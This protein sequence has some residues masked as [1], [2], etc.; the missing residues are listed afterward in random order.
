MM[1]ENREISYLHGEAPRA[2]FFTSAYAFCQI[3]NSTLL[4][5]D[6]SSSLPRGHETTRGYFHAAVR[7]KNAGKSASSR[8]FILRPDQW[9]TFK[10][11]TLTFTLSRFVGYKPFIIMAKLA[12]AADL[13]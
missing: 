6:L 8:G 3:R 1:I 7:Q 2:V 11:C 9:K 4:R 10:S 5:P 13:K 12:D